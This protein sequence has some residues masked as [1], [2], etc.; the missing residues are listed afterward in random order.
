MVKPFLRSGSLDDVLAL[1]ENGQPIYACAQQLRET[2]RLRRQQQAAD[3]LAIPQPNES[4]TRI[5]WYAPFPGKVTS[6]LAASD[7]QRAQAV[8]HLEHCLTI[9]RS[10]TEQAQA[11]DHPSHRL[12]GALLAKAMHMP[13]PN[14]VYLVDDRP[15][16]T[17]WGFIKPQAQS[18]DD[19][20]ACLRPLESEVEK[21]APIAAAP[22][23]PAVVE[24][25]KP[26]PAAEP[27][28]APAPAA[29]IESS[30][31]V[32]P[33]RR[34]ALWLL[35]VLLLG[36]AALAAWLHRSPPPQPAMPAEVQHPAPPEKPPR[37][38]PSCAYRWRTRR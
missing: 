22:R 18:P 2:L 12:F 15:V 3:C 13:D 6:W 38:C 25:V 17:F 32:R 33:R 16:L 31:V 27:E 20:L 1:G 35:P 24:P 8:R 36:S 26:A 29:P 19:P 28:P 4:G 11:T 30:A 5:D 34:Y 14:H 7:A 9:F 10:L 21:P 37:R 23:K